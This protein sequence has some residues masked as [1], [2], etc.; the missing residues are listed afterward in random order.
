M[1][2]GESL[3]WR[4]KDRVLLRRNYITGHIPCQSIGEVGIVPV[5]SNPVLLYNGKRN[6]P[7]I[8]FTKSKSGEMET[9]FFKTIAKCLECGTAFKF[10]VTAEERSNEFALEIP[11]PRCGE[12]ADFETFV[13]CDES[14][15]DELLGDY[16]DKVEEY[17][18]EDFD[19]EFDEFLEDDW[20]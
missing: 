9:Q 16:E 5:E 20:V 4:T 14:E 17:E 3:L 15:Y 19:D 6:T 11:C 1:L 18:F 13:P 2:T 7:G 8:S 12:P 10:A